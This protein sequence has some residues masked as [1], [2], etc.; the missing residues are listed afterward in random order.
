MVEPEWIDITTV[1]SN[2]EEQLDRRSRPAVYRH[3]PRAF[4]GEVEYQWSPGPAPLVGDR[5]R[6]N[7]T[8]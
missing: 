1:G 7:T 6:S 2:F 3:R 5:A 4:T 8:P